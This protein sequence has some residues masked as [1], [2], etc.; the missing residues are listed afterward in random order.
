MS[1]FRKK[2]LNHSLELAITWMSGCLLLL[3]ANM[4]I[5]RHLNASVGEPWFNYFLGAVVLVLLVVISVRFRRLHKE[6][7]YAN[8]QIERVDGMGDEG[9]AEYICAL[10]QKDGWI[11]RTGEAGACGALLYLEASGIKAQVVLHTARR[12]LTREYITGVAGLCLDNPHPGGEAEF[13][14]ITNTSFTPQALNQAALEGI[15]LMD[16]RALIDR[17]AKSDSVPVISSMVRK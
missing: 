2:T 11:T 1:S 10:C 4:T 17:L 16:R 9:F 6:I 7:K 15:R 8:S 13:W 3:I 5:F 14:C 12:K